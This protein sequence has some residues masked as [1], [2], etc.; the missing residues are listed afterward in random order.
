MFEKRRA[1]ARCHGL[2]GSVYPGLCHFQL[3]ATLVLIAHRSGSPR[4]DPGQ[5]ERIGV[6]GR[7]GRVVRLQLDGQSSSV[8]GVHLDRQVEFAHQRMQ[9]Q[10]RQARLQRFTAH[11]SSQHQRTLRQTDTAQFQR[12]RAVALGVR[13]RLVARKRVF[14]CLH[15]DVAPPV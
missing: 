14:Q 1:Q 12:Q 9:R 5:F 10:P 13:R 15:I 3:A 7:H 6:C 2:R 8:A 11:L 4:R